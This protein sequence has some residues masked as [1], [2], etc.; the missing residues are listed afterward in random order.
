MALGA[1]GPVTQDHDPRV[2]RRAAMA[3]A[4][5]A[6]PEGMEPLLSLLA[7]DDQETAA[8]AAYGLGYICK[9]HED[10]FVRALASRAAPLTSGHGDDGSADPK[11]QPRKEKPDGNAASGVEVRRAIARAIGRCGGPLAEGVLTA[12]VRAKDAAWKEPAALGLSDLASRKKELGDAGL[13]ALLYAATGNNGELPPTDLAFYGLSRVTIGDAFQETTL[14]GARAALARPGEAR[15]FAIKTLVR[16]GKEAVPDLV[17]VVGDKQFTVAERAEAARSLGT[18]GEPGRTA[19]TELVGKLLPDK[20]PFA[21]S[22]L[23]GDDFAILDSLVGAVGT[24]APKKAAPVLSAVAQ[25]RAPGEPPPMLAR[26]LAELRCSAALS[27]AHA[28]YDA[29][30][31]AKCDADGTYAKEHAVLTALLKAPING[32]AKK[33]AFVRLARSTHLRVRE[34][35]IEGVGT[36]GELGELGRTLLVEALG[37]DKPGLVATAA[38]VVSSHPERLLVLA[39]SEKRA[40]LDP[41]APPPSANPAQ[42][43]DAAVSRA[44]QA[45]LKKPWKEDLVE[46]RLSLMDAAAALHLPGAKAAA[47]AACQDS[48]T[49][50]RERAQKA[51]RTLGESHATCTAPKTERAAAPE[52]LGAHASA[53]LTLVTDAGELALVL[54]P[55]LAPVTV[56]RITSLA[57]SGFYKGIV[58]HRVVPAFVVQFGDPDG[59]GYGGSGKLLRCE[60]SPVPFARLDVG[61]ALAGRDT[62]SSQLFVTL[63]RTPHLD[64]EYTRIGHATGD[65]DAVTEGDVITDVKVK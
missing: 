41:R 50:L 60:T 21:I 20:D 2:R 57:Q 28:A 52:V 16:C 4:R 30:V 31:L 42:E 49:T 39:E 46:T 65:W 19:A 27:L 24:D 10:S 12:W 17:R 58:V 32:A 7:D 8:W 43:V 47:D 62:G 40:A 29:D 1:A 5:I 18:L 61:M 64:G 37:L 55:E 23:G 35:A 51:L 53:T 15:I 13:L 33:E 9:G 36:H 3:L 22:A 45:A 44:L 54:E 59:D 63:A 26:R 34:Q 14:K 11:S 56:A 48:N 38:D 6:D 25:L